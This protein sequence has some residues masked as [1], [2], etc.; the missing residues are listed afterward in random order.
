MRQDEHDD[1]QA[2]ASGLRGPNGQHYRQAAADQDG[3]VGG[4]ESGVDGFA[5]GAEISE[6][7]KAVDQVG[8]RKG[9]RR[10]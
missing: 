5:G 6:I 3:G 7:P 10:T 9:R 2:A 1:Q 8:D 4:A